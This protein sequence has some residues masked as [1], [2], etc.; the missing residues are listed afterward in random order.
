MSYSE[1]DERGS[2]IAISVNLQAVGAA[3][4]GLIPLIIN[5]NSQEVAGVPVAV[6]IIILCMMG[7]ACLIATGLRPPW[8]VIRGDGTQVATIRSRGFL[9]ELKANVEVFKDWRLVLMIPA[10][11]PSETF[12]VYGGSV[13]AYGNDL[14]TRCLLSFCAVCFQ[15][16]CGYGLQ[17]ILDHTAWSRRKRAFVSLATVSTPLMA[18]WIWEIIRVRNY[19]RANPPAQPLDWS[20][21]RFGPT[22]VLFVMRWVSSVLFQY[23]ILYFLSC[24]SNDP[25]KTAV[26]SVSDQTRRYQQSGVLTNVH[27]E[28]TVVSLPLEKPS[29][30]ASTRSLSHTSTRLE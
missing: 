10:F 9:E 21:P 11:L 18:S 22:F 20:E 24:M 16:P 8:K 27:R 17:K 5:R 3:I 7:V 28:S 15:I 25:R 2:F 4:G 29:A 12:L 26:Y 6:Y 1:E 13:N 14:R 23:L 30:S 19:D